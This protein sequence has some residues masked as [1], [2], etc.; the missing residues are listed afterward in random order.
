MAR[1]KWQ[2]WHAQRRNAWRPERRAQRAHG[3][4][5]LPERDTYTEPDSYTYSQPNSHADSYAQHNADTDGD[6]NF[7][8]DR[9]AKRYAKANSNA[10]DSSDTK[11]APYASR[12]KCD[13]VGN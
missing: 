12:L 11:T 8:S 1:H 6:S 3:F 4:Q 2:H 5:P 9:N 10:Q 13:Q 7:Y